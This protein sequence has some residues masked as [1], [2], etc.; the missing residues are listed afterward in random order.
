MAQRP[1]HLQS[2]YKRW[3]VRKIQILIHPFRTKICLETPDYTRSPL[4]MSDPCIPKRQFALAIVFPNSLGSNRGLTHYLLASGQRNLHE[5]KAVF[6]A[7]R[8]I[9]Q[10]PCMSKVKSFYCAKLFCCES[11]CSCSIPSLGQYEVVAILQFSRILQFPLAT[12]T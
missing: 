6:I 8:S 9:E 1:S 7:G 12:I 2:M 5:E 3:K 4:Q 11:V 10:R